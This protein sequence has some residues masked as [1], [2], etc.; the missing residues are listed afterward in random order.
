MFH[1][2]FDGSGCFAGVDEKVDIRGLDVLDYLLVIQDVGGFDEEVV[3]KLFILG[4]VFDD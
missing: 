2:V 3:G 1:Y 4:G